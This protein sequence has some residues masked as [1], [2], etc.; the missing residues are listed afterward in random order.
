MIL[1]P[2]Q[3]LVEELRHTVHLNYSGIMLLITKP[4]SQKFIFS[5]PVANNGEALLQV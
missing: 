4:S 2:C 1:N 3:N 5:G